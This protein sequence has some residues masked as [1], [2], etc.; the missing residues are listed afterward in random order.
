[1]RRNTPAARSVEMDPALLE[2][3]GLSAVFHDLTHRPATIEWEW[4]TG[5]TRLTPFLGSCYH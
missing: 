4:E 5:H 2:L 3:S 1:M